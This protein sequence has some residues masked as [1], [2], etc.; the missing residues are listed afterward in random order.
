M[1]RQV[2]RLACATTGA[3][4]TSRLA[5]FASRFTGSPDLYRTDSR[6][7]VASINFAT[8]HDG[9]T[10]AD[11]VSYDHKHNEAN[12]EGGADG[13]DDNR[14]WN[15]GAEGPTNDAAILALRRRQQRNVLATLFLSQGVPMLLHGDEM[16]RTQRGNNNVYCQDNE[17]A[18]VDWSDVETHAD[19]L[20]FT[21]RI[22]EL[23]RRHPVFRRRRWFHDHTIRGSSEISWHRPD[24]SPMTDEDWDTGYAKS[25]GVF[26]NG[27]FPSGPDD[28][29][30]RFADESF[31][32]LFNAHYEPIDWC[33]PKELGP[34]WEVVV[35]TGTALG[36][37]LFVEAGEQVRVLDRSL[38][39]LL[40]LD[41]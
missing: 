7:P 17:L 10:L 1:E 4:A 5:E 18:W 36:R 35:S 39:V 6:R 20:E 31:V 16:G 3:A 32:L 28:Q 27:E 37:D 15:C 23:R 14:S 13:T 25:V 30:R 33:I 29:G 34:R 24:G 40:R 26:L 19:L 11:L 12:G 41:T 21:R 2:P 8:A 9:F 38:T 22:I